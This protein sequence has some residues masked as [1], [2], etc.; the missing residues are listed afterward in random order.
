[1]VTFFECWNGG[2]IQYDGAMPQFVFPYPPEDSE[3]VAFFQLTGRICEVMTNKEWLLNMGGHYL[4]IPNF[5]GPEVW[6]V[7]QHIES[8]MGYVACPL[9]VQVGNPLMGFTQIPIIL[10]ANTQT[11]RL[12]MYTPQTG[13]VYGQVV[14]P[15]NFSV[16]NSHSRMPANFN[17]QMTAAGEV[18][19]EGAKEFMKSLA[20]GI[21]D[22]AGSALVGFIWSSIAN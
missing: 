17:V 14:L 3:L 22:K 21:G 1:M 10:W 15:P 12:D 11:G 20:R 2:S 9:P 18:I 8:S 13:L 6:A 5:N 19:G 16:H 7:I 4:D